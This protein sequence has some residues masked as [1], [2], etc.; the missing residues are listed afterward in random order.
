MKTKQSAEQYDVLIIGAG[1]SGLGAAC[2]LQRECP[3]RTFVI[4]EAR[5]AIGG[6]WD[7]FRYPGIRSDSDLHT[8]GYEFKP[9]YGKPIATAPE[10][11][12]YLDEVVAENGLAAHIRF[13]HRVSQAAWSSAEAGW[14]VTTSD[15]AG[16]THQFQGQF[17]WMCQGYYNYQAGYRP[18][19]PGEESFQGLI[20]HPQQWPEE[21]DYSGK[22]M[23]V[24]GSGATA[25]TIVPAVAEKAAHVT[26]L[27]RSPSYYLPVDN[28]QETELI[29]QLRALDIPGE[30]LYEIKRRQSLAEG[31][32]FT[33]RA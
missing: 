21:L 11:R 32:V 13:G 16:Q 15:G 23:V 31:K 1:V 4:L 28:D 10:I 22:Q 29:Q 24:I 8:Y 2:H 5:E 18:E 17:L 27:Q 7:L 26:Q 19:I 9:W 3:D 14:T 12:N 25:A 6:T 30:W 20:I 33:E